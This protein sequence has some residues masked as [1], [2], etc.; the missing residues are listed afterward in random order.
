MT[1]E[2]HGFC[3]PRF[4]RLK[5]AFVANF[6][7]DLELGASVAATWRG[8]PV[9][10]LWAGWADVAKTR[11]WERDTLTQIFSTTKIMVTLCVLRLVDQGRIEL[12]APIANCWP[13]FAAGGKERVSVRDFFTHQAGV[14]GF[15]PPVSASIFLDWEAPAAGLAATPH[16]FDGER[17]VVDHG[18]TYGLIGG[19]LIRRVDGRM[20]A[21]F[22]REEVAQPAG[23]DFHFGE[24]ELPDASRVAELLRLAP[25]P[26]PPPEGL[27]AKIAGSYIPVQGLRPSMALNP[28]NNGV[29]NARSIARGCAIFAGGGMLDGRRY[30]SSAMVDEAYREHA[31]GQCPYLGW[32]RLGL[33][34]GLDGHGFSYPSPDCYGWGGAGGS[35]GWIDTR[36]GYSFGYAPNNFGLPPHLDI[37]NARLKEALRAVL[38]DLPS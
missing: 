17:R 9:V 27:L 12:D 30:L 13:E 20:P 38:A 33:G 7:A 21:Q 19:E 28:S 36:R 11:P 32:M 4:E 1:I 18:G 35:V 5:A 8:E 31:Y 29:A 15:T 3:D 23:L 37:R 22:F 14:P 34:F 10:D 16:W 25:P 24:A 2:I 6:E 26:S